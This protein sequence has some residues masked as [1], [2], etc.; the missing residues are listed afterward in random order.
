MKSGFSPREFMSKRRP[1]VFSDSVEKQQ[2]ILDRS[3]LEYYLTTLTSRN[4]EVEF[5]SF[6]Q[7]LAERTICPNLRPQTGPTGGGD[8]KV[9]SETYPVSD[10][11]ALTWYEGIAREASS[12]RWAFA[13]SAKKDW[14]SKVRSDIAKI[15]STD[16]GYSKG[17]FVT[18][19]YVPDRR[20]GEV[21][22]NLRKKHKTLD[23]RILDL[24]WI[25]DRIF[26]EGLQSLAI[27][28]LGLEISTRTEVEKGPLDVQKER[29]LKEIEARIKIAS[30]H[31]RL[32]LAFANDCID[33]AVLS[34]GL[35]HPRTTVDGR[36]QRAQRVSESHGTRHQ[37]LVSAYQWAWTVFWWFEDY[38]SFAKL[39]MTVE[40]YAIG[41]ENVHDLEL[42]SNLWH[43]L[44]EAAEHD[45]MALTDFNERTSVLASELERLGQEEN[46]PSTALQAR[47][48]RLSIKLLTLMP[49][50]DDVLCELRQVVLDSEGLI[51]Y[52]LEPQVEIIVELGT[53]LGDRQSYQELCDTVLE[54]WARRK[55]EV[56]SARIR[57][58]VGAQQLHA[59]RPYDAIV[60]LG[61][62]LRSLFK[63]ETEHDLV[64]AL[65]LCSNAYERIGL[66]WAARGTLLN[67]ASIAMSDF[68]AHSR[69]TQPQV[70]CTTRMKWLEMQLGRLPHAL[71]WHEIDSHA[72]RA[73]VDS[74][75]DLAPD[76]DS[77][78]NFD[79]ILGILVLKSDIQSLSRLS[80]LP[81]VLGELGLIQSQVAL[82]FALGDEEQLWQELSEIPEL[83]E[84]DI[85]S[86]FRR[87]RHQP[88]ADDLPDG[89]ILYDEANVSL[90]SNLIG[91]RIRLESENVSPCVGLAESAL[92]ALESLMATGFRDG[93]FPR[94]PILTGSVRKSE[95]AETLFSFDLGD[96]DGRPHLEIRC[97]DFSP[98]DMSVEAQ[99]EAR[100]KL[101]EM[102]VSVLARV[103]VLKNPEHTLIKLLR[104][105]GSLERAVNFT[106]G[107][108]VQGNVLGSYPKTKISKWKE[109]D[110][111]HYPLRRFQAWDA[112]DRR[113]ALAEAKESRTREFKAGQGQPP[114]D[115]LDTQT[116][117][118]TEIE[119]ISLIR[120]RLWE[121]AGWSGTA[122]F[123]TLDH[124]M[125][126]VLAPIFRDPEA[127]RQIFR[128]W[129]LELGAQDE[130]DR[131]RVSFIR[132]ID[133]NNPFKYRVV[134]GANLATAFAGPEI[135]YA[136]VMF[137]RNTMEPSSD[138]NLERFLDAVRTFGHYVL[139]HALGDN[140]PR[141]PRP[142][143]DDAIGKR[144]LHVR[145]AWEVGRHDPDSVGILPDDDP[146]VP[147]T[148]EDPPVR[149]L[150]EWQRSLD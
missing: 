88:A 58:R 95:I 66:L 103:F 34:R 138:E 45:A 36:F 139:A 94:E 146:I 18:N 73:F 5:A 30:S 48:L 130:I 90:E 14:R 33:A 43:L 16:R 20:R 145:E 85:G 51:G 53:L 19:Q 32:E 28:E 15:A 75:S 60:T 112:A 114:A 97:S 52:P 124:S 92:A 82:R 2:P 111:R 47:S 108:V 91:C 87:W 74:G 144:D 101:R 89:P 11:L 107:F 59:G 10:F 1:E 102:L 35:G 71:A 118:H 54:V 135:R 67:G 142:I 46:R 24:T 63:N 134:I 56:A 64:R 7:K 132:G 93:V 143:F 57:L 76:H 79:A 128:G 61:L 115:I 13:F 129:R 69:V 141:S 113:T 31:N 42:L 49:D 25:L 105:E 80:F 68:W 26:T 110:E 37:Q 78:A 106:C 117:K 125:P 65:Y 4:Q 131:L 12:E 109:G 81:D 100:N 137:R 116:V 147:A 96:R 39:Y 41:T 149:E 136:T 99:R 21:E 22:D 55:G 70:R 83:E 150:M 84:D 29:D 6:A 23:V 122:Y 148:Q 127:G 27:S 98:H 119:S 8:S 44:P 120:E 3:Q 9:D 77:Q 126:P 86:F 123:T 17:F 140:D 62:A 133:Q 121:R 104:D 72:R 38:S 40:S 50:V